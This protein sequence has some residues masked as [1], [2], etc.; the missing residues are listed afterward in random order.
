[1]EIKYGGNRVETYRLVADQTG[2]RLQAIA[3]DGRGTA[4]VFT[5]EEVTA[6]LQS[7]AVAAVSRGKIEP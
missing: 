7:Y 2:T 5:A 4:E 6:A 3:Q 1:V